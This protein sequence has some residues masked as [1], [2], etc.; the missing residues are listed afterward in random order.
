M[1]KSLFQTSIWIILFLFF[2]CQ[3]SIGK[4]NSK[5]TSNG[6]SRSNEKIHSDS[7][8]GSN[9][10][11]K[12]NSFESKKKSKKDIIRIEHKSKNQNVLDSIK[13]EKQKLK[14]MKN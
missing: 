2:S 6:I 9:K 4:N 14:T 13:N 7:L 11:K 8:I 5:K 1:R 12:T 3:T 10:K